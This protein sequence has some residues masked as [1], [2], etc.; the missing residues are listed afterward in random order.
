MKGNDN[1]TW[2]GASGNTGPGTAALSQTPGARAEFTFT[3]TSVTW[4]SY[5]ANWVGL[6]DVSVDGG[7]VSRV[8]LYS[9]TEQLRVPIFTRNLTP[10]PHTLRIDVTGDKNPASV[11]AFVIVDAFD[12]TVP[13]PGVPVRRFAEDD[14][15]LSPNYTPLASNASSGWV[16]GSGFP[17]WSGERAMFSA[18]A[19]ARATFTFTGTSVTWIG[20]RSQNTGIAR[21]SL[22]GG[23]PVD[24][25]TFASVIGDTQ[26]AIFSQGGLAPGVHTL[27]IEVTGLKNPASGSAQITI[28]ALDVQNQ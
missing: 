19:G 15:S 17:F 3:G 22:D 28:D 5:R 6:V 27:T 2:S 9:P 13:S 4:I 20:D 25:D 8:D 23:A 11:G 10:G 7:P 12:V 21:V 1:K 26:T 16:Q 14:P 24:V 18:M